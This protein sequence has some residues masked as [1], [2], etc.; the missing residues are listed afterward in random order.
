MK[1]ISFPTPVL[2]EFMA[3]MRRE[4]VATVDLADPADVEPFRE[5][6]QRE[7]L[8]LGVPVRSGSEMLSVATTRVS[9]ERPARG[10]TLIALQ[11]GMASRAV[12]SAGAAPTRRLTMSAQVTAA[13]RKAATATARLGRIAAT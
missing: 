3:E 6:V 5:A 12:R 4:G 9:V 8:Q 2:S 7:A 10:R 13:K 11:A 1:V